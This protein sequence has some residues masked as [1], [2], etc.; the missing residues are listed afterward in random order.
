DSDDN[1]IVTNSPRHSVKTFTSYRLPDILDN[2]LT[3]GGGVNWQSKAG[4]DLHTYTQG[5]YAVTNLMA[6][7]AISQ[8]LSASINFNN[9]F[10]RNYFSHVDSLRVYVAPRNFMTSLKY[11]F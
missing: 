4:Q 3:I 5:S 7:Y 1:R 8:N 9:V 10:D 11:A 6:R 2:K